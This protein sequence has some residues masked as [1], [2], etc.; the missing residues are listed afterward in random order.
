[1]PFGLPLN[2]NEDV[3]CVDVDVDEDDVLSEKDVNERCDLN[4]DVRMGD[5]EVFSLSTKIK[6]ESSCLNLDDRKSSRVAGRAWLQLGLLKK[7]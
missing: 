2:L 6:G 1:M 5:D 3:V 4:F 7:N